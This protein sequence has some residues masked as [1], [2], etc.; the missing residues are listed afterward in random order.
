MFPDQT[1]SLP[2]WPEAEV[3]GEQRQDRTKTAIKEN[4][5]KINKNSYK[6]CEASF[7]SRSWPI[8]SGPFCCNVVL[9]LRA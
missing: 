5:Y 4:S 6:I 8:G 2:Q 3:C 1:C 9:A 7:A